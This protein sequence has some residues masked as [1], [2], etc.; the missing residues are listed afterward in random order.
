[1]LFPAL[2]AFVPGGKTT[3]LLQTTKGN[4][5]LTSGWDGPAA[6]V[7]K[8]TSGFDIVTRTHVEG[9]AAAAM[10]QLEVDSAALFINNP[11]ICRA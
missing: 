5:L 2:P 10:Q 9:H 8:G 7:P 11:S 4:M 3:G 6:S 1:M